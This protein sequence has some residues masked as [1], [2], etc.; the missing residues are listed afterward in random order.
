MNNCK[1][2]TYYCCDYEFMHYYK[3]YMNSYIL[4]HYNWNNNPIIINNIKNI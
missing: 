1:C 3:E 4:K 2:N